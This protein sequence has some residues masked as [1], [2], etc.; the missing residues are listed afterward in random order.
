MLASTVNEF[1]CSQSETDLKQFPTHR[2]AVAIMRAHEHCFA[3]TCNGFVYVL[4]AGTD[5]C[6]GYHVRGGE[7]CVVGDTW[8]ESIG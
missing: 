1:V 7:H 2:D 5:T 4:A 3:N 6:H 8:S